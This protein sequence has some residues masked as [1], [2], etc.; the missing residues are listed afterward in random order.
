MLNLMRGGHSIITDTALSSFWADGVLQLSMHDPYFVL[1]VGVM[2][3]NYF[4]L[5]GSRHPFFIHLVRKENRLMCFNFAFASGL[6][7]VAA[8]AIYPLSYIGLALGHLSMR[9]LSYFG[10]D[11]KRALADLFRVK[12]K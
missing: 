12:K 7:F 8:P 5:S 9:S 3:V 10:K 6:L 1:P 2:V 11:C 4:I